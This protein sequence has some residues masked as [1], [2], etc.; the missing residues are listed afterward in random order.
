M[1]ERIPDVQPPEHDDPPAAPRK[2]PRKAAPGEERPGGLTLNSLRQELHD[3]VALADTAVKPLPD[4]ALDD[5]HPM[6]PGHRWSITFR[7]TRVFDHNRLWDVIARSD[8]E[9][10]NC[11]YVPQ[12]QDSCP[13]DYIAVHTTEGRQLAMAILAA[14]DQ[15][16]AAALRLSRLDKRSAQRPR[17]PAS[18]RRPR[19]HRRCGMNPDDRDSALRYAELADRVYGERRMP[20]GTRDLILA[21]GWVTLRDPRRHDPTASTWGR[22][23]EVL[24]ADNK[25]MWQLVAEDAPR[26]EPDWHAGPSGCQAPMVRVDRLCGRSTTIGFAEFDPH[27]G[28][29]TYWGFCS[30]PRCREYMRPIYPPGPPQPG[31]RAG[32]DSEHRRAAAAVLLLELGKPRYHKAAEVVHTIGEWKPPSFGFLG[33]NGAGKSS[34]MRMIGCVSPVTE[35][36]LRVLGLDPGDRRRR[37]PGAARRRAAG[38]Q[39]RHRAH[40]LREPAHLR[41]L[42]R[43]AAVGDHARAPTSCS[44]SCSSRD[45]ARRPRRAAVGRA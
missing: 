27:T 39:P 1:T 30:R 44:S 11:V 23:R 4:G 2:R 42:L 18:P 17:R 9:V 43:S 7:S 6:G 45:R 31:Q 34:T 8:D 29:M 19:A 21:L 25:R 10:S 13:G 16:D 20:T 14:C 28:W 37:D 24:N 36:K 15:A 38:G 40:G 26:Y 12:E 33:P 41:P 22:A 35:G 3:L 32:G 5:R